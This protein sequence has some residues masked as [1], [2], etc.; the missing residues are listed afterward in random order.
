M[1]YLYK[2]KLYTSHRASTVKN[3]TQ[4][5]GRFAVWCEIVIQHWFQG[6]IPPPGGGACKLHTH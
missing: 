6:F 3:K 2:F 1:E 5:G 4:L